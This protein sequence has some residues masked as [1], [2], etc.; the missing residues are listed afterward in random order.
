MKADSRHHTPSPGQDV[1]YLIGA[2]VGLLFAIGI[3][4]LTEEIV[5]AIAA[6]VPIGLTLGMALA[7]QSSHKHPSRRKKT[8]LVTILLLGIVALGSVIALL[9]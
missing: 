9:R 2:V 3:Y 5:I 7:E 1:G 4:A 6:S 8:F